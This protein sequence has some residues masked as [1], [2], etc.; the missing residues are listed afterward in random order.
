MITASIYTLSTGEITA[1]VLCPDDEIT[2][3][4]DEAISSY[5]VGNHDSKTK[6]INNGTVTTRPSIGLTIDKTQ[7][8]SDP[9][10]VFALPENKATISNLPKPTTVT[11]NGVQSQTTDGTAE[12]VSD[13]PTTL[14]IKVS[15]WPYLD[16]ELT[17][18]AI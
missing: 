18:E 16:E 14:Q 2:N 5:V 3:Q 13:V 10:D 17:I 11:V 8:T 15:S 7:I 4:F 6:Y 1:I 9:T 12:I